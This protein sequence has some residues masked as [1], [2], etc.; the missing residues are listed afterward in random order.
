M[1]IEFTC[2]CGK[3][4]RVSDGKA[5]KRF[6]CRNCR[7]LL[8][9]PN[10]NDGTTVEVPVN[11]SPDDSCVDA[12]ESLGDAAPQ[13][14][15]ADF[16]LNR[17]LAETVPADLQAQRDSPPKQTLS[18]KIDTWIGCV[19]FLVVSSGFVVWLP[20]SSYRDL[21]P[22]ALGTNFLGG[23]LVSIFWAMSLGGVWLSVRLIRFVIFGAKGQQEIAPG[24]EYSSESLVCSASGWYNKPVRV[25]VDLAAMMIHFQNCHV[26][27]KFFAMKAQVWF[28]CPLKNVISVHRLCYSHRGGTKTDFL[29]I[30][31]PTGIADV[32]HTATNYEMLCVALA[33]LT[34]RGPTLS[35]SHPVLPLLC[36][37]GA[38][39]GIIA[40]FLFLPLRGS[41]E[42][43]L[44][45][46]V[47]GAIGGAVVPFVIIAVV[48]RFQ[49]R[50]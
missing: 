45:W 42:S 43:L 18:A 35:T 25:V 30:V 12:A 29:R 2:G 36:G 39:C 7:T 34:R 40:V 31:T 44:L 22:L 37:G 16:D 50:S 47:A 8:H 14:V 27:G 32:H 11:D 15:D 28:S 10:S 1:A 21:G 26:P 38:F 41:F 24:P 33:S 49:R 17:F 19:L 3:G 23:V 6:K 5:G 48:S 46:I 9:V 4:Y 20:V 13:T